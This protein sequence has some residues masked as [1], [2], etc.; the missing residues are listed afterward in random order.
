MR[1]SQE[2]PARGVVGAWRPAA[3]FSTLALQSVV[4]VETLGEF[5]VFFSLFLVGLEFSPEKLRKVSLSTT[6][7]GLSRFI[8][9]DSSAIGLHGFRMNV[10]F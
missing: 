7:S 9:S 4:Q 3:S 1:A 6:C 10:L 5:G 8:F 2:L